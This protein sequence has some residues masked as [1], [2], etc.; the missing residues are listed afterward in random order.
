MSRDPVPIDGFEE[1]KKTGPPVLEP[2]VAVP[3][4]AFP[5]LVSRNETVPV[6]AVF[7]LPPTVAVNV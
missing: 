6:G 7:P 3:N 4:T 1:F 5:L 2:S